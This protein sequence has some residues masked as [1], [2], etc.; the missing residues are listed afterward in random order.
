MPMITQKAERDSQYL[1][2][3]AST[4]AV[5][6]EK[7]AYPALQLSL[8][9]LDPLLLLFVRNLSWNTPMI[10][11][12]SS[13]S[14]ASVGYASYTVCGFWDKIAAAEVNLTTNSALTPH[15]TAASFTGHSSTSSSPTATF[16]GGSRDVRMTLGIGFLTIFV[17]M[18][19]VVVL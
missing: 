16:T 15:S 6:G 13:E 17:A 2:V 11:T 14:I 10:Y 8:R 5:K 9:G 19:S 3:I 4:Y 12:T 18:L 1:S 7:G